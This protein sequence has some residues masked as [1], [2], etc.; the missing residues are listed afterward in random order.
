ME[1]QASFTG[2]RNDELSAKRAQSVKT[3]LVGHGIDAAWLNVIAV[4]SLKSLPDESQEYFA[5]NAGHR[6][7]SWMSALADA[8]A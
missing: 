3:A 4:G 8:A 7:V 6:T 1:G 5:K 2:T